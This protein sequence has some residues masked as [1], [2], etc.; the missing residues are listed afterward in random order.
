MH[1]SLRYLDGYDRVLE[2]VWM[3]LLALGIESSHVTRTVTLRF[4]PG[5]LS[6]RPTTYS[7]PPRTLHDWLGNLWR[8]A[9][10]LSP[11]V[12]GKLSS[13]RV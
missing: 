4:G 5:S 3:F 12:R 11:S 2:G 8:H 13:N 10:L 9:S 7:T 6:S 1:G